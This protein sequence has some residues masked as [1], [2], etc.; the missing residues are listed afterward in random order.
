MRYALEKKTAGKMRVEA[1]SLF[2]SKVEAHNLL[3]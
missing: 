2:R 3:E 1:L